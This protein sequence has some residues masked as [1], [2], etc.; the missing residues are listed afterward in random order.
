[1]SQNSL[2]AVLIVTLLNVTIIKCGIIWIRNYG[3]TAWHEG[4]QSC[5][6][7]FLYSNR[8]FLPALS[9][10]RN[11]DESIWYGMKIHTMLSEYGQRSFPDVIWYSSRRLLILKLGGKTAQPS[12]AWLGSQ[13]AFIWGSW[14]Q[15]H[16]F[17]T[18]R[19]SSLQASTSSPSKGRFGKGI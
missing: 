9:S 3:K 17:W 7:L 18:W 1:M 10:G 12:R 19:S 4:K 16:P 15:R 5:A 13:A 2:S 6:L 8:G 14:L 11:L